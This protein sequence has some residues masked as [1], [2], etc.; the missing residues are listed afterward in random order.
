MFC[1]SQKVKD[2]EASQ[3]S[4][5]WF[6]EELFKTQQER[7]SLRQKVE[8]MHRQLS[9]A[10]QG[11][12]LT[13]KSNQLNKAAGHI[14]DLNSEI[15]IQKSKNDFHIHQ[16]KRKVEMLTEML[17]EKGVKSEDVKTRMSSS[18]F[19]STEDLK[20][21]RDSGIAEL[22]EMKKTHE[23]E[24]HALRDEIDLLVISRD[25]EKDANQK[26][27]EQ[28]EVDLEFQRAQ[29]KKDL[30]D[31]RE[32]ISVY[33]NFL[34]E[35]KEKSGSIQSELAGYESELTN[36]RKELSEQKSSFE[37]ELSRLSEENSNL[38]MD[39]E[40]NSDKLKRTS[41]SSEMLMQYKQVI[42]DMKNNYEKEME[43]MKSVLQSSMSSETKECQTDD[44]TKKQKHV[45]FDVESEITSQKA[46][47][48]QL[49][50]ER[51][52]YMRELEE[53]QLSS[54]E[55][56]EKL[57]NEIEAFKEQGNADNMDTEE[58]RRESTDSVKRKFESD[59][60][61][62]DNNTVDTSVKKSRKSICIEAPITD[63]SDDEVKQEKV[64]EDFELIKDSYEIEI[65][66]LKDR[67]QE[68]T[69][70]PGE[71]IVEGEHKSVVA[72]VEKLKE[73]HKEEVS[74]LEGKI[75]AY[76]SLLEKEQE[77]MERLLQSV[78]ER[79]VSSVNH[80][81]VKRKYLDEI[82]E[83][84]EEIKIYTDIMDEEKKTNENAEKE[85]C[86]N[87]EKYISQI[88][89]LKDEVEKLEQLYESEKTK[90]NELSEQESQNETEGSIEELKTIHQNEVDLM[91]EEFKNFAEQHF[92]NENII[93]KEFEDKIESLQGQLIKLQEEL[94]AKNTHE[95]EDGDN[96]DTP[97][98]S[99]EV[100]QESDNLQMDMLR[101]EI[102][103]LKEEHRLK[104]ENMSSHNEDMG[105]DSSSNL[106]LEMLKAE[107]DQLKESHRIELEE[108]TTKQAPESDFSSLQV[109]MLKTEIEHLKEAHEQEIDQLSSKLVELQSNRPEHQEE[110]GSDGDHDVVKSM[111]CRIECL[112]VDHAKEV[113]LLNQQIEALEHRLE[114]HDME[115]GTGDLEMELLKAEIAEIKSTH[116][117]E[118]EMMQAAS[119]RQ[120]EDLEDA[121]MELT[122]YQ[123]TSKMGETMDNM[124]GLGQDDS[125]KLIQELQLELEEMKASHDHEVECLRKQIQE[126]EPCTMNEN[127]KFFL[128]FAVF[129]CCFK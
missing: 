68:L 42:E 22:D 69:D 97:S 87:S 129:L 4:L 19:G 120:A 113:E 116:A 86:D 63:L 29:F 89:R 62:L 51:D 64:P 80:A 109:E 91:K 85:I 124:E 34:A 33:Q 110:V 73:K 55:N 114:T 115:G 90:N 72:Q 24:L 128:L 57:T 56:I 94:N 71:E 11:T 20:K 37:T 125:A 41:D 6:E 112:E 88:E 111:E 103:I 102:E 81:S 10:E 126:A 13:Q 40:R 79:R 16:L 53:L 106:Q 118:L 96:C 99:N 78:D 122:S 35:E 9:A 84:K 5:P 100:K 52:D 74:E 32:E 28:F 38:K 2:L 26:L 30:D 70:R 60:D 123:S 39:I 83:L 23:Q 67:I 17:E 92:E 58:R 65:Q 127:G 45:S 25:Q 61:N 48:N 121:Q 12:G 31:A 18:D 117:L 49:T 21:D 50:E 8:N 43:N 105:T 27:L 77:K 119:T 1:F 104:I 66:C 44:L 95:Q 75:S 7:N 98:T 14:A 93:R 59:E 47:I 15:D 54:H 3:S 82:A 108:L 76:E 46:I 101:A 107:I 36:L